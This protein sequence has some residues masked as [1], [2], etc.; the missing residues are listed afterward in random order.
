MRMALKPSQKAALALVVF[1]SSLGSTAFSQP[2]AEDARE[3]LGKSMAERPG[4]PMPANRADLDLWL[5]TK[6]YKQLVAS[7]Q[8]ARAG[9]EIVRDLNWE[10]ARIHEGAT[11]LIAFAY[12][13]ELWRLGSVLPAPQ[14]DQTKQTAVAFS[15][16]ALELITLDGPSC[17]DPTAPGHHLDQLLIQHRPVWAYGKALP[18]A[19]RA[20]VIKVALAVERATASIRGPDDVLCG[21]GLAE[22]R[23]GLAANGGGPPPSA[24]DAP[25]AVGKSYKAPDAPGYRP[26]FRD[27]TLWR[28][29]QSAARAKMPALLNSLMKTAA[30]AAP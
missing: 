6:D 9:D 2:I 12:L 30:P 18:E 26:Q 24:V 13:N 20:T 8:A 27:Q 14:G 11:V 16:Y 21:G 10:Q 5:K 22:I 23:Q 25:G 28:P 4:E 19:D 1:L 7:L 3:T 29:Q 15:L 17:A